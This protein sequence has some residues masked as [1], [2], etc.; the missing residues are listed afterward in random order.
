MASSLDGRIACSMVDKISGDEYY[1]PL[2]SL[3]CPSCVEGKVTSE[4]YHSLTAHYDSKNL[5]PKDKET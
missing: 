3:E 2:A 5:K 4:H 1:S